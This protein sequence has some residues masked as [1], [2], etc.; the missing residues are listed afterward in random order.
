MRDRLRRFLAFAIASA[1]LASTSLHALTWV[2]VAQLTHA[3]GSQIG[4]AVAIDGDVA[5]ISDSIGI[6]RVFVRS[7]GIWTE[8]AELV[9]SSVPTPA[10]LFGASVAI[11]GDTIAVGS[12][13]T[14]DNCGHVYV[15]VRPSGGWSGTLSENARLEGFG[16]ENQ[17]RYGIPV[18]FAGD[19]IVT[20]SGLTTEAPNIV[21]VFNKPGS[22]WSGT[23]Y[24]SA[25]AYCSLNLYLTA[26]AASGDVI[27]AGGSLETVDNHQYA[28]KAF[29]WVKPAGGWSGFISNAAELLPSDPIDN[30]RFGTSLDIDGTS[31]VVANMY[32]VIDF[33]PTPNKSKGYV[34]EM[35]SA[36]WAGTLTEDARLVGS[37]VINGDEFGVSTSISGGTVVIGAMGANFGPNLAGF[38][39]AYVFDRPALGWSGTVSET[40]AFGG[41]QGGTDPPDDFGQA[42]AIS[43]RTIVVGSPSENVGG[44]VAQGVAHVFALRKPFFTRTRFII[45]GPIRVRPGVPVEFPIQ[46]EVLGRVE[47]EATGVVLIDDGAGQECRAVLDASGEGSCALSFPSSGTY[48]VRAH[49]L[50]NGEFDDSTSPPLRVLVGGS[51]GP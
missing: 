20:S 14:T 36:G 2:E 38:G 6:A 23:V 24:P 10:E 9:P 32:P 15:F 16:V 51:S 13:C 37:D 5:V 21:F 25:F 46:V 12:P 43:G 48:R 44:N 41:P 1:L 34:F 47:V 4:D 45:E 3:G 18:A 31:V 26:I 40:A 11:R 49:F 28:G 8:A 33:P 39:A 27:V 7:G 29:V 22:G 17:F 35:P 50:G 30:G 19:S 42:V